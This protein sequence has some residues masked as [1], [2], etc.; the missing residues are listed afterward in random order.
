[1]PI[2]IFLASST[3]GSGEVLAR[4]QHQLTLPPSTAQPDFCF[5]LGKANFL[6]FPPQFP[7]EQGSIGSISFTRSSLS[8]GLK[9]Y[10]FL[11]YQLSIT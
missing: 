7:V 10:P 1:M 9:I 5:L 6:F 4:M 11:H 8:P 3:M 2:S